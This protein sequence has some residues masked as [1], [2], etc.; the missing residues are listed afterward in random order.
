MNETPGEK[1]RENFGKSNR[2]MAGEGEG[3]EETGGLAK[4]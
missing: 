2:P 3:R 1:I 4:C